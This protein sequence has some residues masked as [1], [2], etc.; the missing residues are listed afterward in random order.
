MRKLQ[1]LTLTVGIFFSA[2][3]YAQ[4]VTPAILN[5]TGGTNFF[6][7]YRFEWSFGE[8]MAIE[9][10]SATNIT[11]TNGVLQPGTNTPATVNNNTA[12][13]KDEIK[14][15]PN[16]VQNMLEID[17][18]SKQQGKVSMTLY[19]ESGKQITRQ[20]FTYYGTGSIQKM[21]VSTY[22]SGAYFLDILLDP[23]NTSVVKHSPFK[24]QILR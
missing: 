11:V 9:T 23:I 21:N 8:A 15:L 2:S 7:F 22:P 13:G 5:T 4:S 12:W 18:L 24:I 20:Q 3:S 10:M 16:P 19:D 14:V 1:L 6:T 17:F